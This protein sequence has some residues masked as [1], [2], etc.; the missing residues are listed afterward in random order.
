VLRLALATLVIGLV[1]IP[2]AGAAPSYAELRDEAGTVL[3]AAAGASYDYPEDGSLVHV[4]EARRI[5]GGVQLDEVVLLGGRVR[6]GRLVVPDHG[7]AGVEVSDLVADGVRPR[8]RP[9]TVVLLPGVGYLVAGQEAV[10]AGTTAVVGLRIHVATPVAGLPAGAE[11]LVAPSGATVASPSPA[12]VAGSISVLGFSFGPAG[13][14]RE[15]AAGYPLATRGKVTGCPFVAGSTHSPFAAPNNLESDNAVDINVPIGTPVLAV[16]DGVI[17]TQ[18]GSLGSFDP[19]MQGL[20]VHLDTTGRR[21]YYA[22][23]SRIDVVPGQQVRA[24]QQIG[25]SGS[26]AGV[27]HLHFAQDAGNPAVTIGEPAA[28]PFFVQYDETW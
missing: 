24:G 5:P 18:I 1:G 10:V 20:R 9:N 2:A 16:A 26:A 27:A 17:G 19:R 13:L 11:L 7:F 3:A 23:L 28:C 4:G 21:F 12:S 6:A 8:S 22:H 14:V 25:L 15:A